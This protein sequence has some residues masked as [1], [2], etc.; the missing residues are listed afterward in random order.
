[1]R[2]LRIRLAN[3]VGFPVEVDN[4]ALTHHVDSL[5]RPLN[6]TNAQA[7]S[8]DLGAAIRAAGLVPQDRVYVNWYRYDQIDEFDLASLSTFFR[9]IWYPSSDDIEV[10]DASCNWIVSVSHT[11]DVAY[12]KFE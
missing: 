5:L 7:A 1:M 12:V 3:A 4:L 9:D 8:F 2:E 11:G 10:F 6:G